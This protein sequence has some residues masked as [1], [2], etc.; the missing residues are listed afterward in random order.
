MAT[1]V[2]I[3]NYGEVFTRRWV[4]DRLVR[5]RLYDAACLV[6]SERGG[7]IHDEPVDLMSTSNLTA[8]I[9]GRVAYIQGLRS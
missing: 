6:S 5:G 1:A 4:F 8:A 7:G 9:S 3:E 2:R